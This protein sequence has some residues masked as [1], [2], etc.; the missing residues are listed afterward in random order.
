[1]KLTV[2]GSAGRTGSHVLSQGIQRGH[3]I[4]AFT[5]RPDAPPRASELAAVVHGDGRDPEAVT[6][7]VTG[8]DAVIAIVSSA[9]RTGPHET[10]EVSEV[11]VA[12]MTAV[13][14]RRLVITSAYPL[15]GNRPRVPIA[16][17][18]VALRAS[19]ADLAQMERVVSGSDLDWTIAR[20]NRL[21]DRP[22]RGEVTVTR[23]LLSRPTGITRADA[24]ATLLDLAE[25]STYARS[26]VNISGN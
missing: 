23:D 18:R 13:G 2:F 26:S 8:A 6:R 7:A 21:L 24:A 14:A 19:Y 22:P 9:A 3:R 5:R 10:A 25:T 12:S 4:T 11:I 15:V 16:M 20:L 1:V 17:L